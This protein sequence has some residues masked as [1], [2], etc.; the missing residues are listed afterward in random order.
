MLRLKRDLCLLFQGAVIPRS[1][2]LSSDEECSLYSFTTIAKEFHRSV[3]ESTVVRFQLR[4]SQG[5]SSISLLRIH[6][7]R[8]LYAPT[9]FLNPLHSIT[10]RLSGSYCNTQLPRASC[11]IERKKHLHYVVYHYTAGPLLSFLRLHIETKW[12]EESIAQAYPLYQLPQK[13][14]IV[15]CISQLVEKVAGAVQHR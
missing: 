1:V 13:L 9:V 7:N 15:H 2:I 10:I 6:R 8:K 11:F 12:Q 3:K 4:M 5:A 14:L